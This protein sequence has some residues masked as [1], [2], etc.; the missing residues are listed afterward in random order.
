[1]YYQVIQTIGIFDRFSHFPH[2]R[3]GV[4][5]T[6]SCFLQFM[7]PPEEGERMGLGITCL[8]AMI[9]FMTILEQRFSPDPN[10]VP[11]LAVYFALLTI[12]IALS[13]LATA[14]VIKVDY[15]GTGPTAAPP[16]RW[17]K[18]ITMVFATVCL[19]TYIPTAPQIDPK[20]FCNFTCPQP[21]N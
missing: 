6:L 2:A 18:R 20:Y 13:L 15:C 8:L 21:I 16:G 12:I 17:C 10:A 14:I 4:I 11:R 5:I 9:V 1:M 7:L 19:P 3:T